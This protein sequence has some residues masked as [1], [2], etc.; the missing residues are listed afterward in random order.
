MLSRAARLAFQD[1]G[2]R[3][4]AFTW[5]GDAIIAHV[6]DEALDQLQLFSDE[7][8]DPKRTEA[9]LSRALEEVFDGPLVRKLLARRASVR[10]DQLSDPTGAAGDLRRLHDL[11]PSDAEVVEQLLGLYTELSDWRGMVQLYEDQILRGKDPAARAEL[12]RTV[13]RL[14][15]EKL[16]D[17]REAADAWRRVLRMKQGDPE[18]QEGLERAKS[19]MLKRPKEE[20][21]ASTV[22]NAAPAPSPPPAE[23]AEPAKADAAPPPERT[24]GFESAPPAPSVAP[25]TDAGDE[26]TT[27]MSPEAAKEALAKFEEPKE[28][29]KKKKSRESKAPKADAKAEPASPPADDDMAGVDD[30]VGGSPAAS[31]GANGPGVMPPL[32]ATPPAP[33]PP[34]AS[35]A[36]PLPPPA[37]PTSS[38]VPP[39]PPSG[40]RPPPSSSSLGT[41]PPPPPGSSGVSR[42]PPPPPRGHPPLP[43]GARPPLP[44]PGGGARLAPPP[45]LAS[46]PPPLPPS[47]GADDDDEGENVDDADL[48]EDSKV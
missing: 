15:E 9:V 7:V 48:F 16:D 17:P 35:G 1:L 6:G 4:Q 8:G 42:P 34:A 26:P 31:P 22:E 47:I 41:R 45:P 38:R 27:R 36:S 5:L 43:P 32:E 25:E 2:D 30:L 39:P 12:A 21:P 46:R 13:A 14:Y 24:G 19:G 29:K 37:G 33:E 18:A 20:P 11:S 40:T 28:S 3:E 44:P 23:K 10:R